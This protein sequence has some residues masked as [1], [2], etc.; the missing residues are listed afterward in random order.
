MAM[1]SRGRNQP[2][3]PLGAQD[4]ERLALFYAGRYAVTRAKLRSYLVRKLRERGWEGE[5][6][7]PVERLVER[8]AELGYV[9]DRGFAAARAE[10]LTRRGFGVRRV[11][12][13]LRAAGIEEEDGA[14]ALDRARE[15]AWASALRFAERRRIGPF[16]QQLTD[17][18]GR[19]KALAAMLRAGH[20]IG[21][22]RRLVDS[23]PGE[24][25]AGDE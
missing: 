19:E 6:E 23:P 7:P 18:P 3:P 24:V 1:K 20:S 5:G 2:A 14:P 4:L 17:R 12:Q 25:P 9:D 8:F 11:D 16:A 21:L 13:A 22:A 10:A 15:E